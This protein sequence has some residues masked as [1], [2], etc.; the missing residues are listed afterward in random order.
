MNSLNRDLLRTRSLPPGVTGGILH[1]FPERIMQF[2]EG[3]FLRA[4]ADWMIDELSERGLFAGRI[5][6]VQPIRGGMIRQLNAQDGL[7]TVIARGIQAGNVV[8]TRRIITSVSRGLNPYTEWADVAELARKPE[9]RFVFSN[10]TEAGIAYV[11][12]PYTP[13]SCPESFP[14]KVAELLYERFR[15]VGGDPARGLI[16]LP[17][18]LIDQ[19]GRKLQECVLKHAS[20]WNLENEFRHW[21]ESANYFLDTLVDR[22]V[23]GYPR[24]DAA[25]LSEALGYADQ[26]LDA[27]E[28]FH[29]WVIEGPRHLADELPFHK[30]GL[31]VVW[32]DDLAPHRKRK[33]RI[34]NG[35]H[36]ASA[37]AAFFGGVRT[38][39]EMMGDELFGCFVHRA[40][41]E[42]IVPALSRNEEAEE[43]RRYAAAVLD[44]FCNPFLQHQLLDIAINS[45]S[46]WKVRVL[47]SV[48]DG[49]RMKGKPPRL[50]T[51][52]LA[53]LL[54]FYD[55][56][57]SSSTEFY[58]IRGGQRYP[59]CDDADVLKA[60]ARAWNAFHADGDLRRLVQ[61]VLADESLWGMSLFQLPDFAESV[62]RSLQAILAGGVRSAAASLLEKL[63]DP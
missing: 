19:N 33:L 28:P 17:C 35:V 9:L 56:T 29:L 59:I 43:E 10:T 6:V 31:N 60:F 49:L 2:G 48:L 52:S 32:T 14:A 27:A 42:E 47:P 44:R 3:N 30:A 39:Y 62:E 61:T 21:V 50:L 63:C 37:P 34:L 11:E 36:T 15:A 55:G 5:A 38:V 25:R 23:S 40:V 12:E 45:V 58:G 57:I 22:I 53:A 18:E 7:Y 54:R 41:F 51:F 20:A 13:G 46:K 4:F 26:L 16:F 1:D 8:E 24:D